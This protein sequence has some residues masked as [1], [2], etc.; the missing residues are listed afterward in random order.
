MHVLMKEYITPD[1]FA[2]KSDINFKKPLDPAN[3]V[4]EIQ[5]TEEQIKVYQE[6]ATYKIQ[7]RKL[8]KSKCSQDPQRIHCK[9]K[10]TKGIKGNLQIVRNLTDVS[11]FLCIFVCFKQ[12]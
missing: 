6:E 3:S 2:K 11:K 9:E 8:Y 12:Q 10:K 7:T 4:Q 1:R 5:R